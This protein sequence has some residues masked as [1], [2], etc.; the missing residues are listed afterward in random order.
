MQARNR[1]WRKFG[2]SLTFVPDNF[3]SLHCHR[4]PRVRK[5]LEKW[6]RCYPE[7]FSELQK[8]FELR[9]DLVLDIDDNED[10]DDNDDDNEVSI[11]RDVGG[12][13]LGSRAA[14]SSC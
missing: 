11:S 13:K 2:S 10:G 8:V 4:C 12:I 6:S 1:K 5:S 7:F 9:Y 3:P 14:H